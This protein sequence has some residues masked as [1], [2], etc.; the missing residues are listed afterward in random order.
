MTSIP[1]G[2]TDTTRVGDRI[3]V[4][5]LRGRI[6]INLP[7]APFETYDIYNRLRFVIIQWKFGTFSSLPASIDGAFQ[8]GSFGW[9]QLY[10]HDYRHQFRVLL[11]K[12]VTLNA[13]SHPATMIKFCIKKGFRRNVQYNGGS[14][15]AWDNGGTN[16]ITWGIISDSNA[17]P[18]PAMSGYI[19]TNFTD[20]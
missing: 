15:T 12:T 10:S 11:D 13:Y 17:V 16:C 18:D 4:L 19:R 7:V 5:S 20:S 6:S 9:N 3:R 8:A 2:T 14:T 1:Q